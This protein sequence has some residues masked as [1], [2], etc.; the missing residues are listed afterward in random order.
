MPSRKP[1]VPSYRLH[2]ST[3]Q[4]VVTLGGRD[5]YLG[6]Y[7]STKSHAEYRRLL[8]EWAAV[9]RSA[10]PSAG[11]GDFRPS[12]AI[13]ISELV[14]AYYRHAE[15]YYVK[16]GEPTREIIN[17]KHALRDLR[18]LYGHTPARDFGP[19]ALK[20]VRQAMIESGLSRGVI[21]RRVRT[22]VRAFRWAVEEELIPAS[23]HHGLKAVAGLRKGRTEARETEPVR[24]VPD[25]QVDAVRPYVSRQVWAM[26]E[27]Q[28]LTGM[29]PGEAI[30]MRT[31]DVDASGEVW[32]YRPARHKTEHHGRAREVMIGPLA[33]RVLR[34]WLRAERDAYLF[35]PAEA[36]A[37]RRR[38]MREARKTPVQP[39]QRNRRRAGPGKQPG[40]CYTTNSY[41]RAIHSACDKA[42]VGRWHPNRLRHSAATRFRRVAGLEGAQ[43]LLG[44]ASA[45]T[46]EI[47][48]ETDRQRAVE[49]IRR[50]G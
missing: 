44:H 39:S 37:E 2:K 32:V 38:A 4:A 22:I 18:R 31:G 30:I 11:P 42:G 23:V 45:N 16:H 14:L 40:E 47:Y 10:P 5:Y 34:P 7:N 35:S 46:T 36:L 48:A 12:A 24:P 1:R 49:T 28:R 19:L 3:G 13:T 27:L 43:V 20:A 26:I 15:G 50:V 29:R 25:A 8:A 41:C 33:Q 9:D 6:P 21:N 17:V